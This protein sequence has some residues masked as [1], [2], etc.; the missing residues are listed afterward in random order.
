[1]NDERQSGRRST[2]QRK[3]K[4]TRQSEILE[5]FSDA[6]DY[7]SDDEELFD[8]EDEEI[9]QRP[10]RRQR[11]ERRPVSRSGSGRTSSGNRSGSARRRPA[12]R[13]KKKPSIV[14]FILVILVALIIGGGLVGMKLYERLSYSKEE[15]P[16]ESY[17]HVSGPE[18]VPVVIGTDHAEIRAL[19]RDGNLYLPLDF[20]QQNL[21]SRFFYDK[22]ENAVIY[23]TPTKIYR[24]EEGSPEYTIDGEIV[25]AAAPVW[26][27]R[28]QMPQIE[29]TFLQQYA[30]FS[31]KRYSEPERLLLQLEN[32]EVQKATIEKDTQ[33]RYQGGVKSDVL[34]Q[35]PAGSTVA[36]IE[37]MEEWSRVMSDD[38]IIGYVEN[39]R[40]SSPTQ[41][42]VM[43]PVTFTPEE[44][45]SLTRDHK[46]NMAWHQ[47][48]NAAAN[49]TIYDMLANTKSVN[50]ISPTWYF[51]SDNAGNFTTIADASYVQNM[52]DKGIEVWAL[53]DNFTNQVDTAEALGSFTNRQ[54][55]IS[56]LVP[57]VLSVGADGINVDFELVPQEAGPDYVEFIR[58]LSIACRKNN[59]VLSVDNYVPTEYTGY[60]NR[61]EQGAVADYVVIMGY[62]EHYAGSSEAGS[63]AS[64][65]YVQEGIEKT[66]S[67]VPANKV[68]NGIPFYTRFWRTDNSGVESEALTMPVAA[69]ALEKRGVT[70]EWDD[71]TSQYYATFEEEGKTCQIWMEEKESITAKLRLMMQY[72]L[73]GVAE[74]KLGQEDPV[75]WDAIEGYMNDSLQ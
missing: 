6:G 69:Q 30:N 9:I 27:M 38:G 51:L 16:L 52:H 66:V 60:Y 39:K 53:I 63:V 45:T 47:V 58:E 40:L 10:V 19:L 1:M 14:P 28:D 26:V 34:T 57:S 64:L 68:I 37:Q 62:D 35:A 31:A 2:G 32:G 18:D 8:Y 7:D 71:T 59:L 75:V 11:E 20:V 3:K 25:G 56:Q 48:T 67:Q 41:E 13:R 22:V 50:V 54:N 24:F 65:G 61:A 55:L 42:A 5:F 70:A 73:G 23:T 4:S 43:V 49:D 15:M 74:W 21:N 12:P 44:Y 46:I 17:Y 36:V 72:N 33:I 29:L